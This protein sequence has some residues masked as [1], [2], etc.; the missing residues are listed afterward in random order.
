MQIISGPSYIDKVP[1]SGAGS[2]I[3]AGALMMPGAT[4]E[5]SNGIAVISQASAST[6]L[7][8]LLAK[9]ATAAQ[10]NPLLSGGDSTPADGLIYN[11]GEIE[12]ALPGSRLA[13]E[14]SQ[15][16]GDLITVTS[17]AGA[18]ITITSLEDNLD[19]QWLYAVSGA[20]AGWLG[21]VKT[22][23]AGSCVLK[24]APTTA[25]D[26]TTKVIKLLGLGKTLFKMTSDCSKLASG[27]AAGT[28]RFNG[29]YLEV[30]CS[31]SKGWERLDPTKHDGWQSG[32][33]NSMNV[34][35]RSVFTLADSYW[36]PVA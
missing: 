31:A 21:Y 27:A 12:M 26:N 36:A 6:A 7:G 13:A 34:Q 28:A 22:G 4:G 8:V 20:G 35:F 11:Y 9:F 5:T 24:S 2:D 30:K 16:A 23:N 14:Y 10:S 25:W 18:T 15:A 1:V 33:L 32:G 3:V 19:G 29:L 17:A